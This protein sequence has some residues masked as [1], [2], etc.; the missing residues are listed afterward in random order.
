MG[1]NG[2]SGRLCKHLKNLYGIK[3]APRQFKKT[4]FILHLK[5]RQLDSESCVFVRRSKHIEVLIALYVDD[6]LIAGSDEVGVK[7]VIHLLQ[8][9]FEIPKAEV[10]EEFLGTLF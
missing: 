1:Y 9:E 3:Q 10:A 7:V 8:K 6:L 2:N 5:F 4:D